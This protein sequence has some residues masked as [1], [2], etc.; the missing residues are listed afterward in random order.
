MS[1]R[2]RGPRARKALGQHFLVDTGV[3]ADIAAAVRVP[4]GGVLFEIGAGT[5]QLTGTLLDAGHEVVALEIESRLL[6][7]LRQRFADRQ[8]L[9]LVE[10]DARILRM[11]AEVGDDGL[12]HAA[13]DDAGVL[14]AGEA[15]HAGTSTGG[16]ASQKFSTSPSGR[17]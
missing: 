1:A 3:L 17:P 13:D 15:G 11:V 10:G 14:P 6:G 12:V 2:S 8:R 4:E 7:H 16:G 5:G 9:T